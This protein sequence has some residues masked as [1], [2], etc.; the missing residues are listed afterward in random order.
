MQDNRRNRNL[1]MTV[2]QLW[3][4]AEGEPNQEGLRPVK[5]VVEKKRFRFVPEEDNFSLCKL[6][7]CFF[8]SL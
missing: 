1:D 8:I 7:I 4:E 3:E 6:S 2:K 5:I